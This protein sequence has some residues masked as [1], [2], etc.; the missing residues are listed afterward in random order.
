MIGIAL[1]LF[2]GLGLAALLEALDSRVRSARRIATVLQM[3]LL[4]RI[5]RPPRQ[6]RR[7]DRLVTA[8]DPSSA[9]AEAFRALATNIGLVNVDPVARSIMVTSAAK[10][11]GKSTSVANLAVTF[12]R[13]GRSVTLVDLDLRAPQLNRGLQ[14]EPGLTDVV[15]ERVSLEDA[16]VEVELGWPAPPSGTSAASGRRGR[17]EVLPSGTRPANP[18]EFIAQLPLQPILDELE[19]RSDIVLIDA[20]PLLGIGDAITLSASVDALI[21]VA[22]LDRART[23][24]LDELLRT[25]HGCPC[26]KLGLIVTA[27]EVES[28]YDLTYGDREPDRRLEA[29]HSREFS[30][31]LAADHESRTT[32]K[33]RPRSFSDWTDG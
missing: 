5:A 1:A 17:L 29:V 30:I 14:S 6:A 32:R 16:L 21:V 8:F 23:A 20:P 2:L 3:P 7:H 13:A 18:G 24:I 28:E 12:A 19:E 27:A 33:S 10:K 4:G 9:H 26:R 15:F 31:R 11:E 25:L 22:R